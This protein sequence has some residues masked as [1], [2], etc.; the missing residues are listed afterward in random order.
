M[1]PTTPK[2]VPRVEPEARAGTVY[3]R[4]SERPAR[5]WAVRIG[6]A[7]LS[8]TAVA[9]LAFVALLHLARIEVLERLQ[10]LGRRTHRTVVVDDVRLGLDGTLELAGLRVSEQ[11]DPGRTAFGVERMVARFDVAAVLSGSRR[12]D[13]IVLRGLWAELT[14]RNG[15]LVEVDELRDALR[16]GR[17]EQTSAEPGRLPQLEL[18]DATIHLTAV[19][20]PPL[21]GTARLSLEHLTGTVG[22]DEEDPRTLIAEL[23]GSVLSEPRRVGFRISAHLTQGEAPSADIEA[24]LDA[25]FELPPLRGPDGPRVR[26]SGL[27]LRSGEHVGVTGLEVLAPNQA[28]DLVRVLAVSELRVD[29]QGGLVPRPEDVRSITATDVDAALDGR[30]A[31]ASSVEL[32]LAAT[33]PDAD[34]AGAN[35]DPAGADAAPAGADHRV[36]KM[37]AALLARATRFEVEGLRAAANG[38]TA[39]A[40]KA[41]LTF[42]PGG[43]TPEELLERIDHAEVAELNA[44]APGGLPRLS[45]ATLDARLAGLRLSDPL[46]AVRRL[47]LGHPRLDL[48]EP[49]GLLGA[50][51]P[52]ASVI[53]A[54]GGDDGDDDEGDDDEGD[55]EKGAAKKKSRKKGSKPAAAP[56]AVEPIEAPPTAADEKA[57]ADAK[58]AADEKAAGAATRLSLSAMIDRLSLLDV[59][60]TEGEL[61]LR[62]R[63]DG[64]E[65]VR[66][67]GVDA[68]VAPGDLPGAVRFDLETH[69]TEERAHT[70][71]LRIAGGIDAQRRLTSLDVSTSGRRLAQML[72]QISDKIHVV[73]TSEVSFVLH[74]DPTDPER[75]VVTGNIAARDLG[76][77]YWRIAHVPV[78]GISLEVDFTGAYDRKKDEVTATISKLR[79]GEAVMKAEATIKRASAVP[80]LDLHVAMPKQPCSNVARSI[81]RALIPRLGGLVTSGSVWFDLTAWIDLRDSYTFKLD[82]DGDL[83]S[84]TVLSIGGDVDMDALNERRYV[85]EVVVNGEDLNIKVGPG[86][87]A[88]TRLKNLPEYVGWGA[89]A[90]EDLAFYDHDGFRLNLI[91]RAVKMDLDYKRYVYGGSTISQQLVKNLFL[92][93][94]KTLSRKAEEAVLTWYME[95]RVDKERILELYLNCIEYGPEIW[96][97]T[98]A[99]RHYFD[100][101]AQD[102]T[103]L[104]TA[105]LMGLKPCPKCGYA[106]WKAGGLDARWQHRMDHIMKRLR[107]RGWITEEQYEESQPMMPAFYYPGQGIVQ[108]TE[109]RG[110]K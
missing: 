98:R 32:L 14:V 63:E 30:T 71:A 58:A 108:L 100:K 75:P 40:R 89:I 65:T 13:H 38:G 25:P 102:L 103:P 72:G 43:G 28:G 31:K 78:T 50:G 36:Q 20:T 85:H 22:A 67:S 23:Q 94:E 5:R 21:Q 2:K 6:L 106:Q 81:P 56:E 29:M 48:E 26:I 55:D 109:P 110:S 12:P 74:L 82:L 93:R 39:D 76:I 34:P 24:F 4:R 35:A 27:V 105:F 84:C 90:T 46:S 77:D 37:A 73:P 3:F 104:E 61:V 18:E 69:V 101:R 88:F 107:D 1:T 53:G 91:K 79:F 80:E 60:V 47:R 44:Q 15:R 66:L 19:D 57:A 11:D 51:G 95:Q 41:T 33:D 17:R 83:K 7:L 8:L 45:A 10:D 16:G 64:R 54:L 62:S 49:A 99:A 70:T 42:R 86:T 96:G 52:W 9:S 59:R 68:V 97:I 87:R 92:S